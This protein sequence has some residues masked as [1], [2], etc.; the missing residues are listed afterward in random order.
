[1]AF[2]LSESLRPEATV[3]SIAI[4]AQQGAAEG[5]THGNWSWTPPID[6]RIA[7]A[8]SVVEGP[9]RAEN[10][11]A[12][13]ELIGVGYYP[14][15]LVP[16]ALGL[17]HWAQGDPMQAMLAAVNLG[18]DTD[19]LASLAGAICGGLRGIE[20]LDQRLLIEIEEVNRLH[21]R[22]LAGQLVSAARIA[23]EGE[24]HSHD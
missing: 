22:E 23:G 3:E 6:R 24:G 18:G 20:G 16:A 5:R 11:V 9:N 10:L 14:W 1:M 19:T 7:R 13:Y 17:V 2:A 15:E 12:I 21:I 8:L 4:A